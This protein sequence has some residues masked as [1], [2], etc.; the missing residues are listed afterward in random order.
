MEV[1][2]HLDG[3]ERPDWLVS[4]DYIPFGKNISSRLYLFA[5]IIR[6]DKASHAA[7]TYRVEWEHT[8]L[9][10]S[11]I[12]INVLQ[13]AIELA[14]KLQHALD[15][16]SKH[17]LGPDVLHFLRANDGSTPGT[18]LVNVAL[19]NRSSFLLWLTCIYFT[20]QEKSNSKKHR[21]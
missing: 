11:V 13:P 8:A 20:L 16:E 15:E 18:G 4:D 7:C 1:A 17:P 19:C 2:F 6:R 21:N 9:G 3:P 10:E 5:S 12:G 14:R